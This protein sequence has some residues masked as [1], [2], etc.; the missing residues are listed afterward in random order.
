MK[1]CVMATISVMEKWQQKAIEL[2]KQIKKTYA[3][4]KF[5]KQLITG[6]KEEVDYSYKAEK[7]IEWY[8]KYC[9]ALEARL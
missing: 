9:K 6:A 3:P 1:G 4:N 7:D 8:V 5:A 2:E